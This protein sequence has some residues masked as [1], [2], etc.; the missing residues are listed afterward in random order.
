MWTRIKR[1]QTRGVRGHAP[2]GKFKILS[3][4]KK[5]EMH[6]KLPIIMRIFVY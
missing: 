1:E 2:L 5:L 4:L 3:L 6:L